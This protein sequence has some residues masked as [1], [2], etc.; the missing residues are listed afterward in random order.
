MEVYEGRTAAFR[1]GDVISAGDLWS[2]ATLYHQYRRAERIQ[3][4]VVEILLQL[5]QRCAR[6]LYACTHLRGRSSRSPQ[7]D[8]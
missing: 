5:D 8:M 4:S 3:L 2:S 6:A 1:L 7:V